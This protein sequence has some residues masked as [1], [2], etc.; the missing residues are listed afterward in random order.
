MRCCIYLVECNSYLLVYIPSYQSMCIHCIDLMIL[1]A[2]S[3]FE[4][5]YCY[6]DDLES[7]R[8]SRD[9]SSIHDENCICY[10]CSYL[11]D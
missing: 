6:T 5:W 10:S 11:A 9:T 8:Q 2:A 4:H 1:V 7:K 3:T